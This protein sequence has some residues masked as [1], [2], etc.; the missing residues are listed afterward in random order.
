MTNSNTA[1]AA[2]PE[3]FTLIDLAKSGGWKAFAST[4]IACPLAWGFI[5][6]AIGGAD[7]LDGVVPGACRCRYCVRGDIT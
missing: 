2:L 7:S 6:N 1:S 3:N 4:G 5:I